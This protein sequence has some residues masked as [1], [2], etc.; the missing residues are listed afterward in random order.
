MELILATA[1]GAKKESSRLPAWR[2][3]RSSRIRHLKKVTEAYG[4][5]IYIL[6]A[7]HGLIN[8]DTVIDPYD[9][10]LTE[11][12][13]EALKP[14]V[15]SQLRELKR[16]GLRRILFYRG[17]ARKLYLD[18]LMASAL[19]LSLNVIYYG[20]GNMRDIGL[21]PYLLER[22]VSR[23]GGISTNRRAKA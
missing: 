7:K 3:Y 1:C 2:L 15:L 19:K 23:N 14:V 10:V 4:V 6:S 12:K 18:L 11:E 22:L 21:T 5:P 20:S 13:F 17:G 16:K 9:E 8:S